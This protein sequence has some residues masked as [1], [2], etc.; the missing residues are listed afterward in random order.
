MIRRC[1]GGP[2]ST[3]GPLLLLGAVL[4]AGVLG[5]VSAPRRAGAVD[6]IPPGRITA[7]LPSAAIAPG[8]T[9]PL[10][11]TLRGNGTGVNVS[12]TATAGGGFV[13][14]LSPSSG[15]VSVPAN[16]VTTV[17]IN[18]TVPAASFG[19]GTISIEVTGVGSS[20][21]LAK[22]SASIL[23][24]SDG[25]PEVWPAPSTFAAAS[26]T[27]G[28]VSFQVHSTIGTTETV[29][30]TSGRFS[31]DPN[32]SGGVFSGTAPPP[33][34]SLPAG[35][36]IT[37]NVPTVIPARAWAG[38]ANAVQLSVTGAG[39]ISNATGLAL[40]SA[41]LPDSLPAAMI[42]TGLTP[43]TVPA[44]GRDGPVFL[45]SRG[46][47][48]VPCG[49]EGIRVIRAT[50]TDS[51]GMID[52]DGDGADDRVVGTIHIP[53]FAAALSVV[54]GFVTATGDT[55]DL[56]VLAAGRGGVMLLDLRV[57]EDPPFGTWSDFFDVD[58]NG[59]DDRILR[60]LSTPG[61]ATDAGWAR[62]PSGRTV[63]LVADADTGSVPVSS[64]YD[65]SLIVPGT[66]GGVMAFDLQA[67]VD[68]LGPV[69]YAAGTLGTPGSALDLEVRGG[70]ALEMAL[71][72]GGGGI[73]FYGLSF[74]AGAPATVTFTPR[75][76]I[77]LSGMWGAPDARDLAWVANSGDSAY[78][79]L[80]AAAGGIQI[81]RAPRG[82]QPPALVL[83][84]QTAGPA[85]GVASA[86]TGT[87]G[88][89]MR[90]NGVSLL[91]V[92]GASELDKIQPGAAAPYTQPVNL[93]RGQA[94][95][96]SGALERALHQS[97][98]TTA[99]SLRFRDTPGALPDLVVSDGARLLVLKNGT[100][101]ISGVPIAA[102]APGVPPLRVS[103]NPASDAIWLDVPRAAV[104]LTGVPA[105][106]PLRIAIADVRGRRVRMLRISS[107]VA[108][109][110]WDGRDE[111]GRPVASGRY[112]ARLVAPSGG[113]RSPAASITLL[114]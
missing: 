102:P 80:A 28:S 90:G 14:G 44:A 113:V 52:G 114:R 23:A 38:N 2:A 58:G 99:T 6:W 25:R 84:Q 5:L 54:P 11:L 22:V 77:G 74:A 13:A 73:G 67:A 109:V 1:T 65:P 71:A 81:V 26:G 60:T 4:L 20:V 87:L 8:V 78:V 106:S 79:A 16:T 63:A 91:R 64:T 57:L 111:Q 82:A 40:S 9:R 62:A 93:A 92:P 12:W 41:S 100:A 61:F 103:P 37:V 75:G 56:G 108:R 85:V 18:V 33:S 105:G 68:S 86:W 45:A 17:A 43:F 53:S 36:T 98:A 29:L 48:L 34:V 96:T 39:G 7:L 76:T 51:I 24:A 10:A 55:M 83:A 104:A 46:Y 59:I 94:W 50:A 30:L 42:P 66:G 15:T 97:W 95:G 110:R 89:A 27:S 31:P 70:T 32:N 49:E 72:D 112:W 69:P 35:G 107:D 21:R 88:V 19:T 101:A 47:W 3:A